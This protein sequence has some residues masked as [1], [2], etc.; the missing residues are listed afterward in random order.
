MCVTSP[1]SSHQTEGCIMAIVLSHL[2]EAPS[3]R[4][5]TVTCLG[6]N[7]HQ[8]QPFFIHLVQKVLEIGRRFI[9]PHPLLSCCAVYLLCSGFYLHVYHPMLFTLGYLRICGHRCSNQRPPAP[10]LHGLLP[11]YHTAIYQN[12][13]LSASRSLPS[14]SVFCFFFP[15]ISTG[16]NT[17][18]ICEDNNPLDFGD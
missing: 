1:L 15:L 18:L 10:R 7:Y 14:L 12:A 5:L 8:N 4:S 2:D 16:R 3:P 17:D 9:L 6:D 11:P 13:P